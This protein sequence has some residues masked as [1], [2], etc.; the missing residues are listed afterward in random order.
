MENEKKKPTAK[1]VGEA[2]S[3]LGCVIPL[4]ILLFFWISCWGGCK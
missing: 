1:E 2:I 4:I 3:A